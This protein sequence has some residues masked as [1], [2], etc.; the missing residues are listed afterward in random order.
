MLTACRFWFNLGKMV[1]VKADQHLAPLQLFIDSF[2]IIVWGR[3]ISF[4]LPFSVLGS[5]P[6]NKRD[7]QEKNTQ[8]Y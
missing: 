7:R 3:K 2:S 4:P 6:F 8:V 1:T 5:D